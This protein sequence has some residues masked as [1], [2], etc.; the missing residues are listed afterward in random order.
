MP[1]L[2][3]MFSYTTVYRK[4]TLLLSVLFAEA[5]ALLY[6]VYMTTTVLVSSTAVLK[7]SILRPHR[8][9]VS[10]PPCE[11]EF[12][13]AKKKINSSK[14]CFQANFYGIHIRQTN[15]AKKF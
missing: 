1:A 12:G 11:S 9:Y 8:F 15:A 6:I 14:F 5:D 7:P 3:T 4:S 10:F 2:L 13:A